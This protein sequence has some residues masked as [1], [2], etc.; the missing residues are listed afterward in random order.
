MTSPVQST[1][2]L[3][4]ATVILVRE[5]QGQLQ[6]YLIRRSPQS[7]FMP[8][9]YVFPGGRLDRS[10]Q[11]ERL[12]KAHGKLSE[13]RV[14]RMSAKGMPAWTAAAYACTAIRECLEE[15]G[16]FLA[17]TEDRQPREL[18]RIGQL[19]RSADRS[20]G[21]FNQVVSVE[22][23]ALDFNALHRWSHW[24]TPPELRRRYDTK[25]FL[26]SMPPAQKCRPDPRETSDGIWVAPERALADNLSG[27]MP[28]SPPTLVTLH[29]LMAFE[30]RDELLRTAANR[31]WGDA[32]TPRL[33]PVQMGALILEPWDP[34]YG[35][36]A[37]AVEKSL[38]ASAP[39]NVGKPFSRLLNRGGVWRPVAAD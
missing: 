3:P 24:I 15:V 13:A 12:W 18:E 1:R 16:V 5:N 10:D 25:F 38:R 22:K 6:V 14:I 9:M 29:Q 27:R 37:E 31:E 2:P 28:L 4:A 7:G 34:Q 21:W 26:A 20:P 8:N 23:W 11:D 19:A 35:Q 32:I 33:V 36:S 39:L 30:G 17:K